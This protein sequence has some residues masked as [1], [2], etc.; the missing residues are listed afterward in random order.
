M[1]EL[2]SIPGL[3]RI[4]WRRERLPTPG[5]WPGEFHGPTPVLQP[6][7]LHGPYSPW[8]HKESDTFESEQLSLFAHI[9]TLNSEVK[10]K[11]KGIFEMAHFH[12]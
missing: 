6:G 12:L 4:P 3:G 1:G 10:I 11:W 7:E 9:F 2:G 5:F 8:G